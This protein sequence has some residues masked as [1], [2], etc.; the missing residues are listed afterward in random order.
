MD[1]GSTASPS[2]LQYPGL[3]HQCNKVFWERSCLWDL[4]WHLRGQSC[5]Q[6]QRAS[7]ARANWRSHPVLASGLDCSLRYTMYSQSCQIRRYSDFYKGLAG[8]GSFS[9]KNTFF[10]VSPP[11]ECPEVDS[12]ETLCPNG[13]CCGKILKKRKYCFVENVLLAKLYFHAFF[14]QA[15][16]IALASLS[17]GPVQPFSTQRRKGFAALPFSHHQALRWGSPIFNFPGVA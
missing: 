14:P 10:Q 11:R 16:R 6:A 3:S 17:W 15:R 5:L 7:W 9:F 13:P 2:T 12:V 1:E 4:I 8:C